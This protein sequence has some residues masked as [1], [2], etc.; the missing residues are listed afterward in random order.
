MDQLQ[1]LNGWMNDRMPWLVLCMLAL[2]LLFPDPV[3]LLRPCVTGFMMFQTFASSLGGTPGD[4]ARVLSHPKPV[5]LV[6]LSLHV[7]MPL[8]ALALGNL[9]F[10]GQPL[11]TL[12]LV[13]IEASPAAV[14][15]LMWVS[16]GCGSVELCLSIVLLETF[17]SP[18]LL[19]LTLRLLC[20]TVVELNTAGMIQDLLIMVAI[21]AAVSMVLSRI[22]GKGPC[23]RM[24]RCLSPFSKMAVLGIVAANV[25]RCAPFLQEL[26]GTLLLLLLVTWVMRLSGLV[27]GWGL[28]RLFRLPDAQKL[29]VT[30]NSSMRNNATS[31]TLAAQYFPAE[32]VFS[33]S[34]SPLFSQL[35][36]SFAVR[37][38]Q[39]AN[40]RK[41]A[42]A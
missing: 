20:G 39:R 7:L 30:V 23:A 18:I 29:T 3:G 6:L 15:S 31:A 5:L 13:L 37:L 10:P 9:C 26:D 21:P 17:L 41:N 36:I 38:F 40:A 28:S 35:S 2:G 4:L 11:Y 22:A 32:V 25:T 24:K 19:P 33:P 1:R 42:R 14:S 16:I 27:L 12:S 34:V 8:W